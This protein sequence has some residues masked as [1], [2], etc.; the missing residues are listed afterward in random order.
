MIGG[1]ESSLCPI[2][3]DITF[4]ITNKSKFNNIIVSNLMVILKFI[5][6]FGGHNDDYNPPFN[7]THT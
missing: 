4:N 2:K 1:L 3:F 5:S 7:I 6:H